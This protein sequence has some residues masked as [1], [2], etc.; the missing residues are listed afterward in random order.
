[1]SLSHTLKGDKRTLNCESLII[2]ILF[3]YIR[4]ICK[5]QSSSNKQKHTERTYF[6]SQHKRPLSTPKQN[7]KMQFFLLSNTSMF[8]FSLFPSLSLFISQLCSF[9][10]KTHTNMRTP[11]RTHKHTNTYAAVFLA[12]TLSPI[13]NSHSA[14]SSDSNESASTNARLTDF[15]AML[16][17]LLVLEIDGNDKWRQRDVATTSTHRQLTRQSHSTAAQQAAQAL[18]IKRGSFAVAVT[19][20][21]TDA[22]LLSTFASSQIHAYVHTNTRAWW[23]SRMRVCVFVCV[24]WGFFWWVFRCGKFHK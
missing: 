21:V 20:A 6:F 17:L 9:R 1:M 8:T 18:N 24:Q 15:V 3:T 13:W 2:I 16:L 23:T 14:M 19:V 12:L 10:T 11:T 22:A 7:C 5:L 4:Y